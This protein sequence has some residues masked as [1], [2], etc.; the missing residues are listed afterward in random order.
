[1]WVAY[2]WQFVSSIELWVVRGWLLNSRYDH[3]RLRAKP[4][5]RYVQG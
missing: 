2:D 4:A 3:L 1:M 5:V